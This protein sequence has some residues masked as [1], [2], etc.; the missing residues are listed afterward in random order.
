MALK[1]ASK[2]M[3]EENE[4][5]EEQIAKANVKYYA[6]LKENMLLVLLQNPQFLNYANSFNI[7]KEEL[8]KMMNCKKSFS[9]ND[10]IINIFLYN[11][12]VMQKVKIYIDIHLF[13]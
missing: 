10:L 6:A 4:T 5:P 2:H 12:K 3:Y 1:F 13:A 7:P 9:V 11:R 8:N